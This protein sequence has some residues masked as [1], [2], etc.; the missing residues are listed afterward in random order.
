MNETY[1]NVIPVR[2]LPINDHF[3]NKF[4]ANLHF[5]QMIENENFTCFS[6]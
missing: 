3:K 4:L 6:C 1:F 5:F 2:F